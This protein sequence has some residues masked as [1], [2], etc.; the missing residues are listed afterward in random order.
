VS[1]DGSPRTELV[2][3]PSGGLSLRGYLH[4][5]PGRT[6]GPA[7][8]FNHGS[9]RGQDRREHLANFYTAHGFAFFSPHRRGHGHSPGEYAIGEMRARL[10]ARVERRAAGAGTAQTPSP[11]FAPQ[12]SRH[13]LMGQ[14]I[15]L[16]ERYLEDTI[17]AVGWLQRHP[18]VDPTR[19]FMSGASH[20]AIQALLAAEADVGVKAYVA[21]A[22]G[23]MG[24]RGNPE[25]AERLINAVTTARTPILLV[26][27][28]NDFDLGPSDVLGAQLRRKGGHNAAL[29]FPPHGHTAHD[30]HGVFACEA[31]DVWGQTVLRFMN[32]AP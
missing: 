7:M 14:V 26:Q 15:A 16:H 5:P 3:F 23:A 11:T 19:I 2:S 8:I 32:T 22:P 29:V 21:F 31:T 27:A 17:A 1:Q 20:G 6:R 18:R 12:Q 9:E 25:L 28:E 24:W 30:G 13:D 4:T 10:L